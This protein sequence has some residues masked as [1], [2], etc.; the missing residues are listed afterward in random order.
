[1]PV[2]RIMSRKLL[3]EVHAS[4][5]SATLK[6]LAISMIFLGK[7]S[8]SQKMSNLRYAIVLQDLLKSSA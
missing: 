1:M 7:L 2:T 6:V 8:N 3:R 4:P 5:L